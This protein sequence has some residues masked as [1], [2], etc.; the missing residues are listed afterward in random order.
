M[1]NTTPKTTTRKTTKAPAKKPTVKK[2]DTKEV[3]TRESIKE[4]VESKLKRYYGVLPNEATEEQIYRSV[5]LSV[6]DILMRKRADQHNL[7]KKTHAKR[8]YY[9]CMEFLVGRSLKTNL[10]NLGL[11]GEYRSLLAEYGF[12]IDKIY[13]E[14]NDAGLGNG[15]LGRLAACFMDSL[16]TL[17]YPATGFSI[18]YE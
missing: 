7:V 18:C 6:K 12:D 2:T 1:A 8:I 10:C 5:V 15:G 9:M 14:E 13:N 16:T 4:A 11:D 3:I 17:G